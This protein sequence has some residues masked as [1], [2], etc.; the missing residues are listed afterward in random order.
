MM[1]EDP[2]TAIERLYHEFYHDLD[3][4]HADRGE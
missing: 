1:M 4:D 2:E 3:A